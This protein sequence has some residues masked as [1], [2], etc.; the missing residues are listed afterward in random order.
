[1]THPLRS[2]Y[3]WE[4]KDG[5]GE[6]VSRDV[7]LWYIMKLEQAI[8]KHPWPESPKPRKRMRRVA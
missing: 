3:W 8:L 1:M 6:P 4:G 7:I 5:D 2:R